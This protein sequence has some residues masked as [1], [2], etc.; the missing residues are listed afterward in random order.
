MSWKTIRKCTLCTVLGKY[1]YKEIQ[2]S[3][4]CEGINLTIFYLHIFVRI[5]V[6]YIVQILFRFKKWYETLEVAEDCEDET[7]RLAFVQQA[8]RFHPDS[9][10]SE[11]DAVKFSAV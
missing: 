4:R 6:H 11:A 5:I 8:K 10:T 7:L 9:A 3:S 2:T 1:I